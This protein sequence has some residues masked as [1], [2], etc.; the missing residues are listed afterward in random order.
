[1]TSSGW[2]ANRPTLREFPSTILPASRRSG[3][4]MSEFQ[5]HH[6]ISKNIATVDPLLR[7]LARNGYFNVNEDT[8]LVRL[9]AT[10]DLAEQMGAEHPA[11]SISP[12]NGG[13][14][15]TVHLTSRERFAATFLVS[16]L[17]T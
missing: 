16:A 6:I 14:T 17:S 4:R 5:N 15:V 12:H 10:R 2:R 7:Q 8:N 3:Q 9:P 13:I 1:M 11:G